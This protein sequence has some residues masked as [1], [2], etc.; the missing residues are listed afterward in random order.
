MV[1]SIRT[2]EDALKNRDTAFV[3][4]FE[5]VGIDDVPLVGGKNASLGEMI[6]QL[7]PKGINIPGGFATT[8]YAYRYFLDKT[9]IQ[10]KLQ[11]LFATLDVNDISSLQRCGRQ[12]RNVILHAPFPEDLALEI[13][14]AYL[15]LCE[16]YGESAP[17]CDR[18]QG[19]E[20][21]ACQRYN[22]ETDVAV[23]SSATAE[24]LP[25]ASFAGQQETY[26]NVR[27][28]RAVLESCHRCFASLF[29][30]RAISYRTINGFD[31]FDAALSVGVQKM[32]RSDLASSGV[33]FSIDTETGFKDAVLVTG[34]YGLGENVV[35]GAVNPDEYFVFKPTLKTGHRPILKK[36]LGSKAIKMVYAGG[37]S[38]QTK[39]V[40]VSE[41]DR[42]RFVLT[43]DEI[44]ILA[45]WACQIEDHY[46]DKRGSFT[47]MDMEWA[48]DGESGNLFI[49]QARPETVQSQKNANLL[50]TYQLQA[51]SPVLVEGCA[52]GE[53]IGQGK[54]RVIFL[55]FA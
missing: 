38:K 30:D 40:P 10:P 49:V 22:Y 12:A 25:D 13:S 44:L 52:V 7:T 47:P 17:L 50:R 19:D 20:R 18:L 31:H 27:G 8:A 23:R 48:K 33:M 35:Q 3:L 54:A 37:G 15:R 9:G 34:A 29:T 55:A 36:S 11:E 26:L 32:V 51:T 46:S 39:N 6:Q 43:D 53:A 21:E 14:K 16:R 4:W 28:A 41:N 45:E 42:D 2:P 5:E 1:Q 24:D